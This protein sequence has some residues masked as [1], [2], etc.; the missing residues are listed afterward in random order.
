MRR[1]RV[2]V[3][4]ASTPL[5]MCSVTKT[6]SALWGHCSLAQTH[7]ASELATNLDIALF[8]ILPTPEKGRRTAKTWQAL[9]L[10]YLETAPTQHLCLQNPKPQTRQSNCPRHAVASSPKTAAGGASRQAALVRWFPVRAAATLPLAVVPR[11]AL[12]N[13][14]TWLQRTPPCLNKN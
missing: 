7:D 10:S 8:F 11:S 3:G 9:P 14:R 4:S 13:L 6:Q 12:Q 2:A 1:S 5:G